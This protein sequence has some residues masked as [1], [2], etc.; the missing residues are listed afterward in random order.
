MKQ[1]IVGYHQ[2]EENHWVA[3][4]QCGHN[5]HVRHNPPWMV[6][7]WVTTPQGRDAML[8]HRLECVK[9]NA[10]APRDWPL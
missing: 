1:P 5:Q 9:C 4:L 3:R 7:T 2:D 8:G 10:H 6:R